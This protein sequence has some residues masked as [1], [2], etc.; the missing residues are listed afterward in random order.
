[1][2]KTNAPTSLSRRRFLKRTGWAA[3]GLTVVAAGSYPLV[4]S[5]VPVLPSLA[6]PDPG[7]G[8]AWVQMLPDG[9][10]RF[11]CPRMEM[12]Q[13]ASLGLSQA[14]AEELNLAQD[15]IDCVLPDTSEIPPVKMTVGS[16][17]I[18]MGTSKIGLIFAE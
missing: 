6:D 11:F 2:S 7:D 9:R 5:A 12:G 13:G 3:V 1:M 4:A 17:S 16:E 14:V 10:A 8:L 18:L 15:R